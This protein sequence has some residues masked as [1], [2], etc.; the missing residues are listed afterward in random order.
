M[1]MRNLHAIHPRI[2]CA[3]QEVFTEGRRFLGSPAVQLASAKVSFSSGQ[4]RFMHSVLM[5]N[6]PF[7]WCSA[8][9]S[10]S[11]RSSDAVP[12]SKKTRLA[13]V[14]ALR[15]K[16]GPGTQSCSTAARSKS[17]RISASPAVHTR[18]SA[19]TDPRHVSEGSWL[20]PFP[21]DV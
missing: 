7:E 9:P 2:T 3:L 12:L 21:L 17:P 16:N 11:G 10:V 15:R 8:V 20:M 5:F 4:H 19:D 1:P 14:C 18:N 6:S 13:F